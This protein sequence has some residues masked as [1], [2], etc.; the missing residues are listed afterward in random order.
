LPGTRHAGL[1]LGDRARLAI[2]SRF[3][4]PALTANRPWENVARAVGV[5][6]RTVWPDQ[7]SCHWLGCVVSADRDR[8]HLWARLCDGR[9]RGDAGDRRLCGTK[10]GDETRG[11]ALDTIA[12]IT[13]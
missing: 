8:Q 6:A 7:D 11:L 1:S 10:I 4:V 9:H 12:P 13:E 3:G 5:F 2:A